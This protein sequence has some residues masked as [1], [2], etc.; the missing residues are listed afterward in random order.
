MSKKVQ[1]QCLICDDVAIGINFGVSTCMPCKAFFRRNAD[2]L[3]TEKFQCR[4]SGNCSITF[5]YRG[6]CNPCRLEKCFRVGMKKTLILSNKDRLARNKL[7]EANRLKRGQLCRTTNLKWMEPPSLIRMSA[8]SI[9]CLSSS[10][11]TILVNIFYAYENTCIAARNTQLPYFPSKIFTNG[12]E[13]IAEIGLIVP[14]ILAYLKRIPEFGSI[15]FHDRMRLIRNQFGHLMH[16]NEL[17]MFPVTSKNL[18]PSLA[19][20]FEPHL[21]CRLAKR[22][23]IMERY[24][25]DPILLRII[26][27]IIFFSSNNSR[28]FNIIDIDAICDDTLAIFAAQNTYVELLWRYVASHTSS[29]NDLIKFMNRMLLFINHI[30]SMN[31][32][33]D[34]YVMKS[35]NDFDQMAPILQAM[36]PRNSNDEDTV[37]CG[38]TENINIIENDGC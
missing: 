26:L 25:A 10:D 22:R 20:S 27:L 16:I 35:K 37:L 21:A 12:F 5:T 2:K 15:S 14:H 17:I 33:I 34:Q 31:M 19:N 11:Q 28:Q 29:E 7:I 23:Q 36:W 13:I 32:D 4:H 9:Q 24:I 18:L 3:N 6:L 8:N 30:Q 38:M 1:S